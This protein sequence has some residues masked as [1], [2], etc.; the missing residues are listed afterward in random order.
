MHHNRIFTQDFGFTLIEVL[1]VL[2]IA[3]ILTPISFFAFS[4]LSDEVTLR[5]FMSELDETIHETQVGAISESDVARIVF[6][7]SGHFYYVAIKDRV[8]RTEINPRITIYSGYQENSIMINQ[9]GHFSTI[10]TFTIS[11]GSIRYRL[12]LLLGQG[13][14][15]YEKT[16][17]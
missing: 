9:L 6:N 16:A 12:V 11:L 8:E 10:K 3:C 13:R 7:N 1:I 5:H 14:Y 15:Y 17:G 4:H 2:S